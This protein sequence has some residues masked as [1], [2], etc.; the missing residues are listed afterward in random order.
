MPRS[1][2]IRLSFRFFFL[3]TEKLKQNNGIIFSPKNWG[4]FVDKSF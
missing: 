2:K 3:A 1:D 4:E